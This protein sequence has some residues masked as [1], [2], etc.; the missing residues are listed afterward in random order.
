MILKFFVDLLSQASIL[1]ALFTMLG[2]I[3]QKKSLSEVISGSMKSLIGFILLGAGAGV[4]VNAITPFG[5]I[6]EHVF[7]VQGV[8]PNNE[9]IVAVALNIYGTQ[10]AMVMILA[11]V[12]HLIIARI[13][14]LKFIFLTGHHIFYMGAMVTVI[15]TVAGLTGIN[16]VVVS[17]II[18]ALTM[19]ISPLLS[20]WAMPK[21]IGKE[22][23]I[24]LGHFS[25]LTYSLSALIGKIVGKNSISTEEMNIPK[26][27]SF[28][29]DN[30]LAIALTMS[31]LYI[32]VAILAGSEFIESNLSN[33]Q[34]FLVYSLLMGVTFA[35]GVSVVLSGVRMIIGEIVPA[36]K[37]ISEKLVPEAIPA[38]D[39]PVVFPYAPNAVLIGFLSSFFGG[40]IGLTIL[41]VI[42]G[43]LIIPGV[44]PHF[45]VGATAGV[46]GNA[47]GGRRGCIIGSFINGL[48][49]AFLPVLLLPI[50][51]DLGFENTTFSDGDFVGVGYIMGQFARIFSQ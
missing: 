16:L 4:I 37:G 46:F 47:T 14:P 18:T 5:Q 9:A 34:H 12:F 3:F 2:L 38:L 22:A 27:L 24:A 33:N 17:A 6:I 15:S 32:I 7:Q 31:I 49:L 21:I 51:G 41:G 11:M 43:T 42:G 28:M 29:R 40:L 39:C 36:F 19:S 23:N 30:I 45:F 50:L 20:Y 8:I 44:V 10:I 26:N 35:T 25:N 48:L 1:V 13:T